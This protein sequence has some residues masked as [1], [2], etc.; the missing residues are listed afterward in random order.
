MIYYSSMTLPMVC[1]ICTF[2][3]IIVCVCYIVLKSL[4]AGILLVPRFIDPG[5]YVHVYIRQTNNH[6]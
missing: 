5:M 3:S 4:N 1:S 2:K 6:L